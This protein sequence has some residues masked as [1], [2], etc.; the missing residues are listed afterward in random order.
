MEFQPILKELTF[1]GSV[2]TEFPPNVLSKN[3]PD[4]RKVEYAVDGRPILVL[5]DVFS[6]EECETI[7]ELSEK[8]GY[9]SLSHIYP[10]D[11][12]NNLRIIVDDRP[13][14]DKWHGRMKD[15]I[16]RMADRGGIVPVCMNQRLRICKYN[17]SGK[18]AA[19]YDSPI[20]H[21]GLESV[22]T[23]MAYLNDVPREQGGATRFFSEK[24]PGLPPI[25]IH[26]KRGS[27][28]IFKHN[29]AHDGEE[30]RGDRKY[31]MRSDVMCGGT[32]GSP[33]DPLP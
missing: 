6:E 29:I 5:Y 10:E 30:L 23:V 14:T 16:D 2:F 33:C 8:C 27:V 9:E 22:Y 15:H 24:T 31:I 26:P 12:R 19:H 18:F 7:I 1:Q 28:V 3:N 32:Y 13:F 25:C 20:S 17:K 4:I 21:D 11:Y